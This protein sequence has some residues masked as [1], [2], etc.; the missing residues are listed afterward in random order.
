[1]GA[2]STSPP[3]VVRVVYDHTLMR[4]TGSGQY[5]DSGNREKIWTFEM[6]DVSDDTVW[7]MLVRIYEL[8]NAR[9]RA[10]EPTDPNYL[11]PVSAKHEI[12]E[13]PVAGPFPWEQERPMWERSTCW[14]E[15]RTSKDPQPVTPGDFSFLY[16]VRRV[17]AGTLA[18]DE[19]MRLATKDLFSVP[20]A[21]AQKFFEDPD[22]LL[23]QLRL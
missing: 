9:L 12:I 17:Q 16:L 7:K 14:A 8:E 19:F 11:A 6:A 5:V 1:M 2:M 3:K 13:P 22:R 10:R 15:S 18:H 4:L 20:E 23:V 21:E